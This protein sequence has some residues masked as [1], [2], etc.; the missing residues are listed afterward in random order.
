M[1]FVAWASSFGLDHRGGAIDLRALMAAS[2]QQPGATP[3]NLLQSRTNKIINEILAMVDTHGMLRNPT[4]DVARALL[5]LL[6]LTQG[7]QSHLE[8]VVRLSISELKPQAN[9]TLM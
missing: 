4:W 7:V 2:G 5:L 6:P 8:R 9:P 3:R 1:V